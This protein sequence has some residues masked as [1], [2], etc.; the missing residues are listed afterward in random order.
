VSDGLVLLVMKCNGRIYNK[1]GVRKRGE[2]KRE[3]SKLLLTWVLEKETG[4]ETR[5]IKKGTRWI[6]LHWI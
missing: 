3:G 1:F 5:Q 4:L 6:R 2:R